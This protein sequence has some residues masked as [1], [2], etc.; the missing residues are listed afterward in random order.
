VAS[1]SLVGY[2]LGVTQL[3]GARYSDAVETFGKL[4]GE[5]PL[6]SGTTSAES[7]E[8]AQMRAVALAAAGQEQFET[9]AK[10]ALGRAGWSVQPS[11]LS[12]HLLTRTPHAS[13]LDRLAAMRS[14]QREMGRTALPEIVQLEL[15]AKQTGPKPK[16]P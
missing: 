5:F 14:D 1:D 3:L 12:Q 11:E 13:Q 15:D 10:A 16:T 7:I 6:Q 4:Q 8:F 9:L 2:E